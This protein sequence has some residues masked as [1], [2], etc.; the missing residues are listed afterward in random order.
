MKRLHKIIAIG[1]VTAIPLGL[2]AHDKYEDRHEGKNSKFSFFE[3]DR[4]EHEGK[5]NKDFYEKKGVNYFFEGKLQEKPTKGFNGTW[6]ISGIK[7]IVDDT[8]TILQ[9][10]KQIKIGDEFYVAAK[11]ENGQIK[12]VEIEQD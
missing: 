1:L 4:G 8:T 2:V 7:V 11:R 6:T 3:D 5:Y 12:A 9:E 10:D